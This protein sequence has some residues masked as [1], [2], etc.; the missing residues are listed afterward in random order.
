MDLVE[1]DS[2]A[3]RMRAR[4]TRAETVKSG[5]YSWPSKEIDELLGEETTSWKRAAGLVAGK[6]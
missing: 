2:K 5:P 1:R 6:D 4:Q 3:L